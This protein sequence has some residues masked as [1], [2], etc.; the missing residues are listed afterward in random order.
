MIMLGILIRVDSEGPALFF[1]Q[2]VGISKMVKGFELM[3]MGKNFIPVD[4]NFAPDK[5]YW[6]PATFRFVKF[7]SMYKDAK[8]RFPHLYDYHL[9]EEEVKTYQFKVPDD[10]RVTRLGKWLREL[11]LDELPN[12][13]NVLTG[14]MSLVGPRPELPDMLPNYRSD[15]MLKFTVKPGITGL[16]QINGRGNLMLQ[17][18]IKYDIKYVKEKA[19]LLDVKIL[20]ETIKKVIARH[21]AF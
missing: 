19:I 15:Q 2:R 20:F 5:D 14:S 4:D 18:T 10:P 17:Q 11:T 6:V 3:K 21:G 1:Q 12:F 13:W 16:A 9:N 8:K 7:R